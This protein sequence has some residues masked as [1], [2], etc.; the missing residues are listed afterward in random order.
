ML[1]PLLIS[2]EFRQFYPHPRPGSNLICAKLDAW[3]D[4]GSNLAPV[5]ANWSEAA[6]GFVSKMTQVHFQA[7]KEF[8]QNW[9]AIDVYLTDQTCLVEPHFSLADVVLTLHLLPLT[10]SVRSH[11][12][13]I[14]LTLWT[15]RLESRNCSGDFQALLDG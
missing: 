7:R 12:F 9:N 2:A 3:F 1:R 14:F 11:S 8:E 4:V 6:L 5:I 10:T 13:F 15:P